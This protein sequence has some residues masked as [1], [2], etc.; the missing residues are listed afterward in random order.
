MSTP[1]RREESTG[2]SSAT[3]A[4][5]M[6]RVLGMMKSLS[7]SNMVLQH[8]KPKKKICTFGQSFDFSACLAE[9]AHCVRRQLT[10]RTQSILLYERRWLRV[11]VV[12]V[13]FV[14]EQVE[15]RV[16]KEVEKG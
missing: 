12:G 15:K 14:V 16:E 3:M 13:F 6:G 8:F 1:P 4:S 10:N 2:Q 11:S 5:N 9:D 7:V